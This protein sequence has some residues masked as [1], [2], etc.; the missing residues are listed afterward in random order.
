MNKLKEHNQEIPKL[1]KQLLEAEEQQRLFLIDA[2]ERLIYATATHCEATL[3]YK[4]LC[5]VTEHLELECR[6]ISHELQ[7]VK[8]QISA[9]RQLMAETCIGKQERLSLPDDDEEEI[10]PASELEWKED[11]QNSVFTNLG[12]KAMITLANNNVEQAKE[13]IRSIAHAHESSDSHSSHD[14]E[15]QHM[16]QEG[17]DEEREALNCQEKYLLNELAALL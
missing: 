4:L 17:N 13:V 3:R 15:I 5:R 9:Q 12:D 14:E 7:Q 10:L 16:R 6:N 1:E 11:K 8:L 2:K